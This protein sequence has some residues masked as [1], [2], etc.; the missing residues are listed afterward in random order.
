MAILR[1]ADVE[2]SGI[3]ETDADGDSMAEIAYEAVMATF[4]TLPRARRRDLDGVAEAVRRGVRSAIGAHWAKKPICH[5]HV[6]A[7]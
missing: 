6:L 3:P 4:D 2:L 1:M 7:V 5:V